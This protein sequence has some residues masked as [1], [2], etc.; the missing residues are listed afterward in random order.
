MQI[1]DG[2]SQVHLAIPE[3][4]DNFTKRMLQE[5]MEVEPPLAVAT[6][7]LLE[8]KLLRCVSCWPW[9]PPWESL[10]GGRI[11]LP[12]TGRLPRKG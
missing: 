1:P 8:A 3:M 5:F 11:R 9:G 10:S 6:A 7:W 12:S 4:P 2:M